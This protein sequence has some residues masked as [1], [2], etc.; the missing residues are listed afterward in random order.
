MPDGSVCTQTHTDGMAVTPV[1]CPARPGP[2]FTT[3]HRGVFMRTIFMMLCAVGCT[4]C[5]CSTTVV[6]GEKKAEVT[7]EKTTPEPPETAAPHKDDAAASQAGETEAGPSDAA[8]PST[9]GQ[10][11]T[12]GAQKTADDTPENKDQ[13]ATGA[14]EETPP[15]KEKA[16][17]EKKTEYTVKES[18]AAGEEQKAKQAPKSGSEKKRAAKKP[19]TSKKQDDAAQLSVSR[20]AVCKEVVDHEPKNKA[21]SFPA[22][23]GTLYCFTHV[24]GARDTVT[25]VHKW[26]HDGT[27]AGIVPLSVW[28]P[29][30]RTYSKRDIAADKKG[31]WKVEVLEQNTEAVLETI[32]FTIE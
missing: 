1:S 7:T 32:S 15:R 19:A 31:A 20:I 13:A 21:A 18:G 23:V 9:T 10:K 5:F 2:F 30:F 22:D 12:A 3:N 17:A 6:A 29:S 28:S 16:V 24:K 14:N 27:L 4:V 11:E 25:I 26:Y 8:E